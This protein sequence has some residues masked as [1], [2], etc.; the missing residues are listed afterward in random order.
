MSGNATNASATFIHLA[1]VTDLDGYV[2][3]SLPE[4]VGKMV[5]ADA[6]ISVPPHPSHGELSGSVL[7]Y[8]LKVT[9]DEGSQA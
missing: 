1:L 8:F 3:I 2:A 7:P 9:Q 4:V 6:V 5:P